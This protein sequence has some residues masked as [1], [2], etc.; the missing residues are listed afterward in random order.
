MGPTNRW[1]LEAWGWIERDESEP[2]RPTKDSAT[3][4]FTESWRCRSRCKVVGGALL[5]AVVASAPVTFASIDHEVLLVRFHPFVVGKQGNRVP[6]MYIKRVQVEQGIF[7]AVVVGQFELDL[8][9]LQFVELLE[10]AVSSGA[11]RVLIDGRQMTGNPTGFERFLYG[12]FAAWAALDVLHR[13][14]AKLK[15]AYL[16][17]EPL[18]DRERYGEM[19]AVSM[20]MDVKTFEG[21]AEAV[22]WLNG[23]HSKHTET[24]SRP[25]SIQ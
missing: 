7:S 13:H 12:S 5:H 8:A 1:R 21:K 16:I 9:Q 20:G 17:H 15:F 19:V 18:R 14:N 24:D 3:R 11:I 23:H 6:A 10:E 25:E 2:A 4:A 22:E